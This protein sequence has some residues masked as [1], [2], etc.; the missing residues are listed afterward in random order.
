[1][2]Y[3]SEPC[4]FSQLGGDAT[5][6]VKGLGSIYF[7]KPLG[8]AIELYHILYV[9]DLMKILFSISCMEFTVFC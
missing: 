8:D 6:H 4:V 9:P 1:M 2:L 5:Y 7:H 3:N